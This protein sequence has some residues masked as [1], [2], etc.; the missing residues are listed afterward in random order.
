MRKKSVHFFLRTFV[1]AVLSFNEFDSTVFP[2]RFLGWESSLNTKR[3]RLSVI[4]LQGKLG[5]PAYPVTVFN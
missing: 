4:S 1:G 3:E 5:G 2:L